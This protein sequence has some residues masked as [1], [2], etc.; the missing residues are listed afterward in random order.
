MQDIKLLKTLDVINSN[1]SFIFLG[2][3]DQRNHW[4]EGDSSEEPWEK[5][6]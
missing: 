2:G 6:G 1:F 5:E 4:D 3:G